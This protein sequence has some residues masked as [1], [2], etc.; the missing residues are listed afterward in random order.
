MGAV[1]G[2][3]LYQVGGLYR[4]GDCTRWGA[5]PGHNFWAINL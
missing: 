3:G 2:V 4:A 1:P 5:V